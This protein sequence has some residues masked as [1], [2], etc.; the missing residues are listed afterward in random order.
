MFDNISD[1][2]LISRND[3]YGNSSTIT[4][5]GMQGK[6][7]LI[8]IE[9]DLSNILNNA[10]AKENAT[11]TITRESNTDPSKNF[12]VT[13]C[14]IRNHGQST[15]SY[16]I[17]SMKM[18]FNKSNQFYEDLNGITQERIPELI[19]TAQQYLNLN[20][21]RYMMKTGSIPSNK[22]VLQANYAD[23][24]G[25]HNG[26]LLRLIQDTWYGA[27]IENENG[28]KEFKLRTAP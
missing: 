16:P 26:S 21:N 18:W 14:R 3:I 19:C 15:L 25:A 28:I 6:Q 9:G 1:S 11:V 7:D 12:T 22:F 27:Q 8:V 20:K 10:Q 5:A 13:G 23:S 2:A 4:Y 24:S 17:T